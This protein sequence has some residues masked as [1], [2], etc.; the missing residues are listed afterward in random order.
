MFSELPTT[1]SHLQASSRITSQRHCHFP[2]KMLKSCQVLTTF[3][4]KVLEN[5]VVW[6]PLSF[7][8]SG[9][10]RIQNVW[11]S[12]AGNTSSTSLSLFIS[13]LPQYFPLK[14]LHP[15]ALEKN[16]DQLMQAFYQ[17]IHR[18]LLLGET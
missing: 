3:E 16:L 4:T 17:L 13:P 7:F 8:L 1:F 6:G 5:P 15:A 2:H 12:G 11:S 10:P 14:Y 18:T 9:R